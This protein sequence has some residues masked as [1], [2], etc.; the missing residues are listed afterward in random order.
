M[1]PRTRVRAIVAVV[2][3]AAAGVAVGAT[4]IGTGED[5][6]S[7]SRPTNRGAPGLELSVLLRNDAEARHALN[8]I[9]D[10][11]DR[12][13]ALIGMSDGKEQIGEHSDA[14]GLL[15]EAIHLIEEVPQLTARSAAYNQIA[16]RYARYGEL[17]KAAV[18]C[19]VNL[20]TI[21]E[22]RDEASKAV[23]LAGLADIGSQYE[24]DLPET[25]E[26]SLEKILTGR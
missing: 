25:S 18:V 10:D 17:G 26:Q 4:L 6:I 8:A 13:F 23:A 12:A 20:A 2:A 15:D 14:I 16:A 3:L 24:L 19:D 22:I 7:P 1:S 11:A 21:A 5:E 9:E